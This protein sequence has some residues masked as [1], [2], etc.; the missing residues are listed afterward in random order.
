MMIETV[1]KICLEV[2]DELGKGYNECI[3]QEGI[4]LLLRK[5]SIRYSKEVNL[6]INMDGI[7]IGFVRADIVIPDDKLVIECKAIDGNLKLSHIPQIIKYL[8]ITG[9]DKG[10][11]VNFNQNPTKSIV[12]LIEIYSHGDDIFKIVFINDS[13]A[14]TTTYYMNDKGCQLNDKNFKDCE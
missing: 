12:E 11:F 7:V 4:A 5:S 3:Y 2:G 9:Y 10:L 1:K 14:T 6:Q 8:K 13:T